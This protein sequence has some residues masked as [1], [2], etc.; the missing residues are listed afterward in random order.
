MP[1]FYDEPEAAEAGDFM[2]P[3]IEEAALV[4]AS[5]Q[6]SPPS[7]LQTPAD[8]Q[9]SPAER[10][11][12]LVHSPASP[13]YKSARSSTRSS[14]ARQ[15]NGAG[16]RVKSPAQPRD[17]QEAGE[18]SAVSEEPRQSSR[19]RSAPTKTKPA[20]KAPSVVKRELRPKVKR[21]LRPKA[22]VDA[23]GAVR[24]A[25][26]PAKTAVVGRPSKTAAAPRRGR[27]AGKAKESKTTA[28]SAREG[29]K[30]WE[31]EKIVGSRIDEAT[32]EHFFRVKWKGFSDK[33][34]TWEPKKNLANCKSLVE[35]YEKKAGK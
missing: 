11:A 21:E 19:L 30:E 13:A 35:A 27:A 5:Q 31:V 7:H 25:G 24:K 16:D 26:R 20:Q 22:N 29:R 15:L 18:P 17:D 8:F 4:T 3:L 1:R 23:K 28:A 32:M 33:D 10:F 12:S 14:L 9:I 6:L 2:F 34:N